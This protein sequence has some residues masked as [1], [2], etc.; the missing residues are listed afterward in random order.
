MVNYKMPST[1]NRS[2]CRV[3]WN[4]DMC[5]RGE[6]P[7]KCGVLTQQT[8]TQLRRE[9]KNTE[10]RPFEWT[11]NVLL[12]SS[13]EMRTEKINKKNEKKENKINNDSNA[14]NYMYSLLC[15]SLTV[16]IRPENINTGSLCRCPSMR[17]HCSVSA[18]FYVNMPLFISFELRA[19]I[20]CECKWLFD[21][22]SRIGSFQ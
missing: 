5:T 20:Y 21:A 14:H 22:T 7:C 9:Q 8:S 4:K 1:L 3:K 6:F 16:A 19:V 18:T 12:A 13:E 15:Q 10:S 17:E 11:L 2:N